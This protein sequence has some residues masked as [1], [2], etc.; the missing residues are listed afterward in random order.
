MLEGGLC[1]E[2]SATILYECTMANQTASLEVWDIIS[3]VTYFVIVL[4]VGIGV[5]N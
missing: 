4:A 1:P 3:L 5:S 2:T